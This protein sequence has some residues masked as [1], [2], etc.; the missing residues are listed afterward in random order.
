MAQ[1]VSGIDLPQLSV[2]NL[3]QQLRAG[4]QAST[5]ARPIVA[6]ACAQARRAPALQAHDVVAI[7]LVCAGQL[8]PSF[9]EYALRDGAA[10]VL[11]QGCAP[12]ECAFRDGPH[13]CVSACTAGAS[14]I[15]GRPCRAS[16][17]RRP[18]PRTCTRPWTAC[19]ARR[20]RA[21]P[22]SPSA[23]EVLS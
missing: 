23:L 5:A 19:A 14:R 4:L 10:G 22:P 7:E 13:C 16:A 12:G 20:P 2:Q 17:G 21:A 15:C 18:K 6:F 1:L 9:I 11:I 3:R 8:P